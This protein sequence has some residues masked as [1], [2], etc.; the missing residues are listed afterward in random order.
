MYSFNFL[1]GLVVEGVV[2]DAI[3]GGNT[4]REQIA[5]HDFDPVIFPNGANFDVP[6][7][8]REYWETR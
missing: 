7:T 6:K 8:V 4:I 5:K 2:N 1:S 3:T